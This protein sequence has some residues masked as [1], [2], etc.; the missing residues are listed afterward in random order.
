MW[1]AKEGNQ[2]AEECHNDTATMVAAEG[3]RSK[4]RSTALE[5]VAQPLKEGN[6]GIFASVVPCRVGR[7][8]G[9]SFLP[10]DEIQM[11][12]NLDNAECRNSW[13]DSM[14]GLGFWPLVARF[15]SI[16]R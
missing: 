4:G 13:A 8:G 14:R 10:E 9:R 16:S 5:M 7:N 3:G 2:G 15:K 11:E 6:S 12:G 1:V